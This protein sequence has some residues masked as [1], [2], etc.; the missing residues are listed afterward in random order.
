MTSYKFLQYNTDDLRLGWDVLEKLANDCDFFMLQRFPKNKQQ[1]LCE[2][3]GKLFLT[4]SVKQDDLCVVLGRAEGLSSIGSVETINLPSKQLVHAVGDRW[5]GCTAIKGTYNNQVTFVSVLPC[6]PESIGEYP[7]TMEDNLR[8][9]DYLLG[10]L[11]DNKT[12]IA[13][14][15]H[16]SPETTRINEII[17][18]HGFK[19]YLDGHKTFKE[20]ASGKLINLD[21][22]LCNFT[23]DISEVI[24]HNTDTDIQQGHFPITYKLSWETN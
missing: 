15:F 17:E 8:D 14:D 18:K 1:A 7:V 23:I 3:S 21:K 2:H 20:S 22:L 19:S 16:F 4:E 24:V 13:G 12:I 5:Q 6:F 10:S 9:I 11:K